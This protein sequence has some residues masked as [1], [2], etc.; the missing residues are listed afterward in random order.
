MDGQPSRFIERLGAAVWNGAVPAG[1][2]DDDGFDFLAD[3]VRI[4]VRSHG[5]RVR[6]QCVLAPSLPREERDIRAVLA[7]FLPH[8]DAGPE[9]LC[10]DESGRVLLI[11]DVEPEGDAEEVIGLFTDAAVHWARRLARA[12][13]AG[14]TRPMPAG[15]MIIFP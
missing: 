13:E 11:A 5:Q 12:T 7:A 15:P 9:V 4:V 3:G 14:S 8:T 2:R 10:T 6:L 1:A